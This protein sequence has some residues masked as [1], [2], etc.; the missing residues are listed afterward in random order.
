MTVICQNLEGLSSKI[1]SLQQ[2]MLFLA[3]YNFEGHVQK[4]Q[5]HN[6]LMHRPGHNIIKQKL[7]LFLAATMFEK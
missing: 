1:A 3:K 6:I 4:F 7:I 2:K 5:C